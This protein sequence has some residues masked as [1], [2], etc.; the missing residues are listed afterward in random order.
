MSVFLFASFISA[1]A[2]GSF[3]S[4]GSSQLQ[5]NTDLSLK[6]PSV[7]KLTAREPNSGGEALYIDIEGFNL[8]LDASGLKAELKPKEGTSGTSLSLR[9]EDLTANFARL[10]L[11][12]GIS[13]AEGAFDLVIG[14]AYGQSITS[15]TT[16]KGDTG[17]QGPMGPQG[18][19]GPQGP[20]GL[21]G[22]KGDRGDIGPT[23]PAGAMGPQGLTGPAGPQGPQGLKGDKGDKGDVGPAGPAGAMGPS[24][25]AGTNCSVAKSG[26][27]STITCQDGTTATVSDGE[28][29]I[30]DKLTIDVLEGRAIQKRVLV[31]ES[32]AP[33]YL[34]KTKNFITRMECSGYANVQDS[35]IP[36]Y[37]HIVPAEGGFYTAYGSNPVYHTDVARTRSDYWYGSFY[38]STEN[39]SQAFLIDTSS[40]TATPVLYVRSNAYSS[41]ALG[42]YITI[43]EYL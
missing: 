42:C 13:L 33:Y 1:C 29:A 28:N 20:Q 39:L 7:T 14:N 10:V 38:Q 36:F 11:D 37:F 9:A 34:R 31:G 30:K 41:H 22:D 3:G 35:S 15:V 8:N 21:K 6:K 5:T 24:G 18:L 43:F 16:L 40:L 2:G 17:P 27:I 19:T 32:N 12:D 23:G 25:P 4:G 26:R